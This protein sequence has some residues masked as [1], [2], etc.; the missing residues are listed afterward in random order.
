[1][2]AVVPSYDEYSY[3]Q[4]Q[5]VADIIKAEVNVKELEVLAADA[6]MANLVGQ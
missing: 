3:Q 4:L 6:D 2:K 5:L 1:M